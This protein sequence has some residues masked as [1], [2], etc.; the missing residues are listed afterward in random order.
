MAPFY[1]WGSTLSRLHNHYE[2]TVTTQF[3][4]VYGTNLIDLGRM[5]G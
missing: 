5:K 3:P 1:G 4:G 2:E